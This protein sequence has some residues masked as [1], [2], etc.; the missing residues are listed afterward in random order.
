V[1]LSVAAD[2]DGGVNLAQVALNEGYSRRHF[3]TYS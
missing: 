1:T 3:V 2:L